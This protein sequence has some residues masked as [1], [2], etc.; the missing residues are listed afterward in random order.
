MRA[1]P[2]SLG[3]GAMIMVVGVG[4]VERAPGNRQHAQAR[5]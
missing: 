5:H 1:L 3:V 2:V 4:S